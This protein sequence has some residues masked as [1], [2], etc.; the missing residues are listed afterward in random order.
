MSKYIV[1]IHGE[2]EGDYEIIKKYEEPTT[3]NDLGVDCISRQDAIKICEERGHDNS[4]YYISILPPVTPQPKMGRCKNC[5]YFEYD[6]LAKVDGVTLIVAHE[7]CI[8]WGG[9]CKTSEDGYCFM[10]EPKESDD[11]K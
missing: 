6:S 9:G 11:K 10:F 8:K 3:K 7:N 1:D 4:A 2:I 5:K